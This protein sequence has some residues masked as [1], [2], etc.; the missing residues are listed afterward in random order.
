MKNLVVPILL[1]S[2]ILMSCNEDDY[3][4]VED[5]IISEELPIDSSILNLSNS[6]FN[7]ANI[8]FP[9]YFLDNDLRNE[10]NTPNNNALILW[11]FLCL[12]L[13]V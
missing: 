4:P 5:V 9:D 13:R 12:I 7:Y 6:S 2:S 3:S 8:S 10:N 1:I 11:L